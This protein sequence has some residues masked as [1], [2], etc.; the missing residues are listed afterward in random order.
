[1]KHR[2][3]INVDL[4]ILEYLYELAQFDVYSKCKIEDSLFDGANKTF[5]VRVGDPRLY[6]AKWGIYE[7][8]SGSYKIYRLIDGKKTI[9]D[10][11]NILQ[12][13][14]S[15]TPSFK[16]KYDVLKTIRLFERIRLIKQKRR[17]D[18]I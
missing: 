10:L 15:T 7:L 3:K 14:Y 16:I 12:K 11:V 6:P 18:G 2:Y 9:R 1:M 8:N 17:I 5:V 13:N 4:K